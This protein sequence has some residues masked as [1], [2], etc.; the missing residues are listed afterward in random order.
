MAP[1]P[2][3]VAFRALLKIDAIELTFTQGYMLRLKCDAHLEVS[4]QSCGAILR[5]AICCLRNESVT[6]NDTLYPTWCRITKVVPKLNE[7]IKNFTDLT[8]C[9]VFPGMLGWFPGRC[10]QSSVQKGLC[11]S[12]L[13]VCV[14]PHMFECIA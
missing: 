9:G 5:G 6:F 8:F 3:V 4:V 11:V 2:C 12:S 7:H 13:C 10:S 14:Y 1:L